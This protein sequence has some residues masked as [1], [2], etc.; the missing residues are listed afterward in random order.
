MKEHNLNPPESVH[1]LR[2]IV[3]TDADLEAILGKPGP[4]QFAKVVAA[5]DTLCRDFIAR[6]PFVLISS[7]DAAGRFDVSP[8]GDPPG[9][10]RVLDDRTLAIPERPGNRRADTFRNVLQNPKVG[11]IFLVPGKSETLRISGTARIIRDA[12][13]RESMAVDGKVPELALVVTVEEAFAHC[14][15]CM[16]R[17]RMWQP[18]TWSADG[19]FTIGSAM[20]AHGRLDM[21]AAEMD[22]IAS[23]DAATRLY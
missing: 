23:N 20:V 1:P 14:T 11:L 5:L 9:F 6:S 3:E 19:L 13:L 4:R 10:V 7:C 12:W 15:K 18:D 22:A 8:K 16:V 2:E 17:S 21:T